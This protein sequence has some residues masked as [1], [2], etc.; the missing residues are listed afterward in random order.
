M[1]HRGK[2]SSIQRQWFDFAWL[3]TGGIIVVITRW[4]YHSQYLFHWDSVQFA[5]AM[6]G[7][8]VVAHRPHP[9]GYLF[10]IYLAK[11]VGLFTKDNNLALVVLGIIASVIGLFLIYYL[12]RVVFH[13]RLAGIIAS[14]LFIFSTTVAFHGMIAEV[15]MV[16]AVMALGV[17]TLIYHYWQ[18]L[19]ARSLVWMVIAL[20]LLG[21][22]R[23]FTELALMPLL[24][25]V[26]LVHRRPNKDWL[27]TAGLLAITNLLWLVPLAILSGGL[28]QYLGSFASLYQVVV[29]G[30]ISQLGS[31]WTKIINNIQT[32]AQ[33]IGVTAS[34][35]LMAGYIALSPFLIT[36][37]VLSKS[38][39]DW[40]QIRFWFL[41]VGGPLILV[42]LTLMTNPGYLLL[43]NL[44]I[45][46]WLGGGLAILYYNLADKT[47]KLISGSIVSLLVGGL[48]IH[49]IILF[50]TLQPADVT[51]IS[52]AKQSISIH[53]Q[54]LEGMITGISDLG[55]AG[56]TA[57]W[58]DS[59]GT[60]LF[61]DIRHLQYYLPD[62]DVYRKAVDSIQHPKSTPIWHA[63]GMKDEFITQ[64]ELKPEITKLFIIRPFWNALHETDQIPLEIYPNRYIVYYDLTTS[65]VRTNVA[66]KYG[67][68]VW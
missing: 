54:M 43:V 61:F 52:P 57:I 37:Q 23:Q 35:E 19:S 60:M 7:I 40:S 3:A 29:L 34:W 22:I 48:V 51:F 18:K 49:Q 50:Y 25:Y 36:H 53:D 39:F 55:E 38:L 1:R 11:V 24:I 56:K 31:W 32:I 46:L 65:E 13:H 5:L 28:G 59:P 27:I 21:G 47:N 58:V 63:T 66:Q 68:K 14:L 30:S 26:L 41:A 16:E 12:A 4:L 2:N 10:Y 17:I 20:G 8:D 33:T 6:Q 62:F 64:V 45:L 44:L 9:P 42:A 67:F 15:Y